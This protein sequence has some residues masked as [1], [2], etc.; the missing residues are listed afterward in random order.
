LFLSRPPNDAFT[1]RLF[2]RL[3]NQIKLPH[4]KI[5]LWS[6]IL[7]PAYIYREYKEDHSYI[8]HTELSYRKKILDNIKEDI[9]ALGVKDHLTADHY[10]SKKSSLPSIAAHLRDLFEA[11]PEKKFIFFT[12]LE[13]AEIYFDLDNVFTVPWGGDITNQMNEYKKLDPIQKKDMTT[14]YSFVSLN[15]GFRHSRAFLISTLFGMELETKGMISCMFQDKIK[16]IFGE[17]EWDCDQKDI[18]EIVKNGFKRFKAADL[19]INDDIEIY[20]KNNNDNVSN[21]KN[22]LS[23]YYQRVFIEFISETSYTEPAF[24]MTEKTLNSI[25][26]YNFP[27]MI[28]SKGSIKFLRNIGLDVFDD[29]IDH[30]YDQIDDPIKRIY[31]A[32]ENNKRLLTDIDRTKDIWYKSQDRFARNVEF[33]KK[34][35]YDFYTRRAEERFTEALRVLQIH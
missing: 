12:S 29:I 27:I 7:D 4:S 5:Y 32:I 35:L 8:D 20:T 28:S 23:N 33:V 9:V 3:C 18:R 22:T 11:F 6:P 14:P 17:T 31:Y 15:R 21:F 1:M 30:S 19:L 26:A 13:N 24:N 16:D 10:N 25:Y 34:D 2:V